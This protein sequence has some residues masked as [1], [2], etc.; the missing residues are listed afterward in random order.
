MMPSSAVVNYA[1]FNGASPSFANLAG[2]QTVYQGCIAHAP[3]SSTTTLWPDW[4]SGDFWHAGSITGGTRYNHVMP[5]N[6]WSCCYNGTHS[7]GANTASSRHS[8]VVNVTMADGSVRAVK[9]SI[10]VTIWWALGSRNGG[11]VISADAY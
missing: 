7:G 5:P 4:P 2:P 10:S 6:T 1:S 11:E 9:S 3:G 8:G